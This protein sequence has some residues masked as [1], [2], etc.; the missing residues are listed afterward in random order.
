MGAGLAPVAARQPPESPGLGST[1]DWNWSQECMDQNL[2]QDDNLDQ[3]RR[4]DSE[5]GPL[6]KAPMDSETLV[7]P[8][9]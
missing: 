7:M 4:Q 5:Q 6:Q 8:Q 2:D 1:V 3:G 9:L